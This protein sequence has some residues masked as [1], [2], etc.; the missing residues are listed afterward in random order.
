ML[1]ILADRPKSVLVLYGAGHIKALKDMFEA[2][3][4]IEVVMFEDLFKK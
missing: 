1:D 2:H 4:L 3:P